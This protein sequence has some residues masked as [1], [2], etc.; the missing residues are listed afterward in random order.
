MDHEDER[1]LAGL[2]VVELSIAIAAPACGFWL[3]HHGAE[4][5]KVESA[6]NLDVARLFGSAWARGDERAMSVFHDTSPYLPEMNSGKKSLGLDLKDAGARD[7][8]LAVVAS[9]DVF[10]TNYSMPAVRSLGLSPEEVRAAHPGIIYV[11]LPGF[12]LDPDAPYYHY[13][14][15]G[16]NQA[17]LVGLDNFTG[18]P[19]QEPAGIT[20]IAPPDYNTAIH[21]TLAVLTAL[22]HR[23]RTGEGSLVDVAQFETTV[24]LLAPFLIDLGLTGRDH[25]RTGNRLAWSA[26]EGVYP[27]R[28]E[29][30]WVAISA[31]DDAAW[32]ALCEVAGL[33]DPAELATVEARVEAHDRL[34]DAI[35]AW[36]STLGAGEAAARLQAAGCPAYPVLDTEA[37]VDRSPGTGEGLVPGAA[38]RPPGSRHARRPGRRPQ[39]SRP[40]RAHRQRALRPGH[41]GAA[42]PT[43]RSSTTHRSTRWSPGARRS[44]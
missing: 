24:S 40:R 9:A 16:P 7:A 1:P 21:A 17:P 34:D 14:A 27:A 22:E 3:A 8:M 26:P 20:P 37:V 43:W 33:G 11:A 38:E 25:G 28:G 32:A 18:Y 5:I 2:R 39:R 44:R 4:V 10:M 41:E 6:K 35:G 31:N 19:D 30:T 36:T 29:D 12:G 42:R 13:L 15:W 23:D